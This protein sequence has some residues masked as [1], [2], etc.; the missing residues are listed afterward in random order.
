MAT[1]RRR[2][3]QRALWTVVNTVKEGLK[4]PSG[5]RV[6]GYSR[7]KTE[8]LTIPS[9]LK[10]NFPAERLHETLSPTPIVNGAPTREKAALPWR[11]FIWKSVGQL[12]VCE[13][14]TTYKLQKIAY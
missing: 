6:I 1:L 4:L 11:N 3:D 14:L 5:Q 2:A 13:K 8:W 9:E 7:W 12:H 10:E